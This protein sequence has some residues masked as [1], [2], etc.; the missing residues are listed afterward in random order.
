MS[1][2][3]AESTDVLEF[4]RIVWELNHLLQS[5]SK[6]MARTLGITGPQRLALRMLEREPGMAT[7]RLSELLHLHPSTITGVLDR[8]E[9]QRLV[10][11]EDH[12][13]D[14]RSTRLRLTP[15]GRRLVVRGTEGT[16]EAAVGSALRALP[17]PTV[18]AARGALRVVCAALERAAEGPALPTARRTTARTRR[19]PR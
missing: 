12:P 18:E 7:L 10:L 8:L 14:G 15:R 1:T 5:A 17:S 16:I 11:R 9:R 3:T 13:R 4:L 2:R 6:R 19:Q